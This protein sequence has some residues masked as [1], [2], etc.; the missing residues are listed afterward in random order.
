[1]HLLKISDGEIFEFLVFFFLGDAGC[2]GDIFYFFS[3]NALFAE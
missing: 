1:M 2:G 3:D